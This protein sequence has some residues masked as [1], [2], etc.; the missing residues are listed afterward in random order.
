MKEVLPREVIE[1][2]PSPITC[3]SV[4]SPAMMRKP[5]RS[6]SPTDE[7]GE[8]LALRIIELLNYDEVVVKL[9][10]QS[11]PMRSKGQYRLS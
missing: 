1:Y 5:T 10:K 11:V 9:K 7:S 4:P 8:A 2:C 3:C 6:S